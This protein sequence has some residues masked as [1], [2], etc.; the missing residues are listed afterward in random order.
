MLPAPTAPS[1]VPT[2]LPAPRTPLASRPLAIAEL[3][4][5]VPPDLAA[6]L[7]EAQAHPQLRTATDRRRRTP[8]ELAAT[9]ATLAADPDRWQHL[10]DFGA[11]QRRAVRLAADDDQ[12]AWL[13]S[14]L[15]G[16]HTGAHDHAG[17]LAATCVARGTLRL[18][19]R[20]AGETGA[21]TLA[22]GQVRVIGSGDVH[23]VANPGPEPALSIH[24]YAPRRAV[25]PR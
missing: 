25:R 10:V 11:E 5:L 19:A 22:A 20:R 15:P 23:L 13:L 4:S 18:S 17:A 3:V 8:A 24:V 16:Q 21:V 14:W 12:E 6:V 9:A 2:A 7:A 1:H